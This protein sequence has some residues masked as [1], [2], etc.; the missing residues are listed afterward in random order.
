MSAQDSQLSET[1]ALDTPQ[2][3]T[4]RGAFLIAAHNGIVLSPDELP[5]LGAG[6]LAPGLMALFAAKELRCRLIERAGWRLASRLGQGLPV[7]AEVEQGRWIVLV[8]AGLVEK[9]D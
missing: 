2:L 9:L 6:D 8:H 5:D 7:L 4:L 1:L 3:S